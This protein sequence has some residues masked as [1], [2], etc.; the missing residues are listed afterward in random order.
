MIG[1]GRIAFVD[2]A[3]G[4]IVE[5]DRQNTS[6][7]LQIPATY[8]LFTPWWKLASMF[9]ESKA[10]GV[11]S[12][13]IFITD[14]LAE[15]WREPND[16]PTYEVLEGCIDVDRPQGQ[17]PE[18]T[19]ALTAA[20][21]LQEDRIYYVVR[22]WG[23]RGRSWLVTHGVM[24]RTEY[25]RAITVLDDVLNADYDGFHIACLF[26]DS[27]Y[28]PQAVYG[29]CSTRRT[30]WACKGMSGEIGPPVRPPNR[31]QTDRHPIYLVNVHHWKSEIHSRITVRSADRNAWRLHADVDVDYRK[32]IVSEHRDERVVNGRRVRRWVLHDQG[33]GNH[34]FDCEVYAAGAAWLPVGVQRIAKEG[35][36]RSVR[37]GIR[38]VAMPTFQSYFNRE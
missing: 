7:A 16:A 2:P 6:R 38:P 25:D 26:I 12:L 17:V 15:P 1:N 19:L 23:E 37:P 10:K 5:P 18:E 24:M 30:A 9:L 22:A 4:A 29:Y 33:S 21:D 36:K 34:Y 27:G 3:T 28:D 8:S 31:K 11:E 32:Q 14:E 35:P 20:A 13:R